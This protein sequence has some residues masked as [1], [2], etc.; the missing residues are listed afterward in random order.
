MRRL[1]PIAG[2]L[3]LIAAAA[4]ANANELVPP[5]GHPVTDE[6]QAVEA[7]V[8]ADFNGDGYGDL[9]YVVRGE[10]HRLLRVVTSLAGQFD[11]D[12]HPPQELPLD[13]YP[14][15]DAVLEVRD[16]PRGSVLIVKD[17]TGGTTAVFSTH[18]FRWDAKLRA[19]R[20]IGLDA[21]LYSRT[22]SHDG[23][24]ASWNL[25]TG[26]FTSHRL[27]LRADGGDAAYDEVDR[28]RTKKPSAP[29]RLENSPSGDDLL[30]WPGA[31]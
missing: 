15:G 27:K 23:M 21:T 30:G 6:G 26:D 12:F 25:L 3:A 13:P 14:L 8:M 4:P 7:E 5:F 22:F 17:L 29:L 19:M 24:E 10:D 28:K 9:A 16:G 18:R 11:L 1:L 31:K 20:L 2:A